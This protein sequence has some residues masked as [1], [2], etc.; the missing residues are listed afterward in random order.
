M[1]CSTSRTNKALNATQS[2]EA[3]RR[4]PSPQESELGGLLAISTLHQKSNVKTCKPRIYPN[5]TRSHF[6]SDHRIGRHK[7]SGT[8]R[9]AWRLDNHWSNTYLRIFWEPYLNGTVA[10]YYKIHRTKRSGLQ[11]AKLILEI[12]DKRDH[13]FQE[14]TS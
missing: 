12:D 8:W 5:L 2:L 10:N 11:R 13:E 7:L 6:T 9:N 4:S 3:S 1:G 14:Y